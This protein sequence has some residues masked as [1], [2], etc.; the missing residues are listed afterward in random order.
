MLN[1]PCTHISEM[2]DLMGPLNDIPRCASKSPR[3]NQ[4]LGRADSNIKLWS[5]TTMLPYRFWSRI[6]TGFFE[7]L[8][9]GT[10]S[11]EL[12]DASRPSPHN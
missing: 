4:E 12:T 11:K 9:A 1:I 7:N 6:Q 3:E 5:K 8:L 10:S 2:I